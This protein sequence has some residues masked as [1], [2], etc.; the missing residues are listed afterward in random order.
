MQRMQEEQHV[1]Y[2]VHT[3]CS[4]RHAT[5][6]QSQPKNHSQH[7]MLRT[8]HLQPCHIPEQWRGKECPHRACP[9][10]QSPP[11]T[12]WL[13]GRARNGD[14]LLRERRC[15]V[16]HPPVLDWHA[17]LWLPRL[18]RCAWTQHRVPTSW[19]TRHVEECVHACPTTAMQPSNCC[20]LHHVSTPLRVG[21]DAA[22]FGMR[23][24]ICC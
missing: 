10:S 12:G 20:M 17:V 14:V 5:T 23:T 16:V 4:A 19:A 11:C 1:G 22:L 13:P 15:C 21:H 6:Q 7:S 8:N 9:P 3:G 24:G 2:A 18:Q